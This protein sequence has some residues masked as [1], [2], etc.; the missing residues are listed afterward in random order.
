MSEIKKGDMSFW[1]PYNI[2]YLS[3]YIPIMIMTMMIDDDDSDDDDDDV[4][5]FV[6]DQRD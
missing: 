2:L 4:V 6:L 3:S 1:S 5:R